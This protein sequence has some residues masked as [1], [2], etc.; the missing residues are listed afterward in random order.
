[1][2]LRALCALCEIIRILL[3]K[4]CFSHTIATTAYQKGHH[5]AHPRIEWPQ[6]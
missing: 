4:H 6:P 2:P 3:R 5:H 1:M